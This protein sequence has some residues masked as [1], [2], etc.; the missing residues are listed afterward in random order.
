GPVEKASPAVISY[1]RT[2]RPRQQYAS[3]PQFRTLAV[4]L[5]VRKSGQIVN[6][7]LG[8]AGCYDE[9]GRAAPRQISRRSWLT[10]QTPAVSGFALVGG[11][12]ITI[13]VQRD[14]DAV[15]AIT[16][17]SPGGARSMKWIILG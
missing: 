1:G 5:A 10:C 14:A 9:G 13:C 17:V 3:M 11:S 8:C 15:D 16:P 7:S 2:T 6:V 4:V 12:P